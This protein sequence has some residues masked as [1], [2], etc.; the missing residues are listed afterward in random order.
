MCFDFN[1]CWADGEDVVGVM[2]NIRLTR[3]VRCF[4]L[5]LFLL[6]AVVVTI[7]SVRFK[8]RFCGAHAV[9]QAVQF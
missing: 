2:D 9:V 5:L 4:G 3:V 7:A 6:V 8:M 1:L